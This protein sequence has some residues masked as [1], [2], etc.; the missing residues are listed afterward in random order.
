MSAGS[1]SQ[2]HMLCMCV[3]VY[4]YNV[5][6][7]VRDLTESGAEQAFSNMERALD[8]EGHGLLLSE[9]V[10]MMLKLKREGLLELN[11]SQAS[12]IFQQA[13]RL[14][15]AGKEKD[16][17]A[18]AAQG[19]TD[20]AAPPSESAADDGGQGAHGAPLGAAPHG[21]RRMKLAQLKTLAQ[22]HSLSFLEG[23][24]DAIY[25]ARKLCWTQKRQIWR[26]VAA[27]SADAPGNENREADEVAALL[28]IE[29]GLFAARDALGSSSRPGTRGSS[30]RPGTRSSSSR[31]GD[32][33]EVP[34][35]GGE[36]T[37]C[38]RC[39]GSRI[40]ALTLRDAPLVM[41]LVGWEW[42]PRRL[43]IVSEDGDE[44][45]EGKVLWDRWDA[46]CG[47]NGIERYLE[48]MSQTEE[49]ELNLSEFDQSDAEDEDD[50]EE[51]KH[52]AAVREEQVQAEAFAM[53]KSGEALDLQKALVL[54][55]ERVLKRSF[56]SVDA[57]GSG[58]VDAE[59]VL[60]ALRA[61]GLAATKADVRQMMDAV[62]EGGRL[63]AL[64]EQL[65][66][67]RAL[68]AQLKLGGLGL[69]QRDKQQL[70]VLEAQLLHLRERLDI[71]EEG[72][73]GFEAY[74]LMIKFNDNLPMKN[75]LP[76]MVPMI[77]TT[78]RVLGTQIALK[79]CPSH[80]WVDK[81]DLQPLLIE[82]V[83]EIS[84]IGL[85][86]MGLQSSLLH[87]SSCEKRATGALWVLGE[88]P[89]KQ[90]PRRARGH[91]LLC[92]DVRAQPH[93]AAVKKILD[94][95]HM[96]YLDERDETHFQQLVRG[97]GLV[98]A[99]MG[100]AFQYCPQCRT[101]MMIAR[102][103]GK[104][105]LM[106]RVEDFS[107]SEGWLQHQLGIPT[108]VPR[109]LHS[110][111]SCNTWL[112]GSRKVQG[113]MPAPYLNN[114]RPP[115]VTYSD[116]FEYSLP[117]DGSVAGTRGSAVVL[118][119]TAL[120]GS[121]V[122][123]RDASHPTIRD[124]IDDRSKIREDIVR[125]AL[126]IDFRPAP[127]LPRLQR[128]VAAAAA[129]HAEVEAE[130]N[131][132]AGAVEPRKQEL[133]KA[134][135]VLEEANLELDRLRVLQEERDTDVKGKELACEEVSKRVVEAEKALSAATQDVVEA[136]ER[137]HA[138]EDEKDACIKA[139]HQSQRA[140]DDNRLAILRAQAHVKGD[141]DKYNRA[142]DLLERA[143]LEHE[144]LL[145]LLDE[146]RALRDAAAAALKA[147]E[148]RAAKSLQYADQVP[149]GDRRASLLEPVL[150]LRA[151]ELRVHWH[152]RCKLLKSW[153]CLRSS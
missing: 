140:S 128:E 66:R 147:E 68:E 22:V 89:I 86:D 81:Y 130:V 32:S 133:L 71:D 23:I 132:R 13:S 61:M 26:R 85:R 103:V 45:G 9:F 144:E 8:V 101:E 131:E 5:Y 122:A 58:R 52:Q 36:Q 99:V 41:Q 92:Y 148:E 69:K 50:E 113:Y 119:R 56:D 33:F 12:L 51:H 74:S 37:L 77:Q 105:V 100:G 83:R 67:L 57:D 110:L 28:G 152:R 123:M 24:A 49:M 120:G 136:A 72:A 31:P 54:A 35:P 97:C 91:A 59:E 125:G 39:V 47:N 30:F 43:V 109:L 96:P 62:D 82:R 141:L 145:P 17:A 4:V 124:C 150:P 106:V 95:A 104:T 1:S 16:G 127:E 21:E 117:T 142:Q 34:V 146:K 111:P 129:A 64:V 63:A 27:A 149:F 70:E 18:H 15:V 46:G 138:L 6:V 112:R 3:H 20:A 65:D 38:V 76:R 108:R 10:C 7:F 143:E 134:R 87:A 80:S 79:N 98:V 116:N 11:G 135:A 60:N 115:V 139:L 137:L 88:Q 93:V 78:F 19:T 107:I 151:H 73:F 55:E 121:W 102:Q 2:I 118:D 94:Q 14:T 53:V 29:G 90:V 40:E 84:R 75:Q 44:E 42:D 25:S 114:H 153:F 48:I 126:V